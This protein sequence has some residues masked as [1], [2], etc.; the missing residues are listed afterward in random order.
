MNILFGVLTFIGLYAAK[1]YS[2]PLFH[3]LVELFSVIIA[4]GIFI[5]AWNTRRIADNHYFLFIGISHL[6][7]GAID[8]AHMLAYK[9]M[10]VFQGYTSNLPTQL[11]IAARYLQSLSLLVA[12]LFIYRKLKISVVFASYIF[13]VCIIFLTTFVY[14]SFPDCFIEGAGLTTFKVVSEYL[15]CIILIM[16]I[17]VLYK[18][19]VLLDNRVFG[20]LSASM[21]ITILSEMSFTLYT[22][23]YG[24]FNMLGHYLKVISFYLIYITIIEK[25]ITQPFLTIFRDLKKNEALLREREERFHRLI[26]HAPIPLALSDKEGVI[27]YCNDRYTEVFGYT[28]EEMPTVKE[29]WQLAYPDDDYRQWVMKSWEESIA[30]ATQ[31]GSDIEAVEY[32]VACKDGKKRVMIISGVIFDDQSLL[33]TFIDI[34]ERKKA[35]EKV[36]KYSHELTERVKELN[37]LYSVSEIVRTNDISH[38]AILQECTALLA[39]AYQFPEITACRITWD[40]H[41]YSTVNF[42]QTAWSQSRAIMVHDRQAGSVEVCYLEERQEEYEGPFLAEER[43]LLNSVADLLGRSTERRQAEEDREKFILELQKALSEVKTLSGLLPICASCKKIRDDS[44]YW[45]QIES[46][47]SKRSS[48][49]FSHAIC[50]ECAEK[51]YPE[52]YKKR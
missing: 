31:T 35:E 5:I 4:C 13:A 38:E 51:L 9:G 6:F 18:S 48:A 44:G 10:G 39:Q 34:T 47:I 25:G 1:L 8:L 27:S 41:I 7:V 52:L 37:C 45:N 19:R 21:V 11:W 42:R 22:D 15:I 20:L 14:K 16:A 28:R 24:I 2:Y 23:V 33:V 36:K 30:R 29:W 3:S 46:Y 50:P 32:N 12:P 26:K 43:H 40:N 49:E 17:A